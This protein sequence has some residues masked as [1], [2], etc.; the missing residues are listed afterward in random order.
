MAE[1]EEEMVKA[2]LGHSPEDSKDS[3]DEAS[4]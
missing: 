3:E 2:D 4:T 1:D